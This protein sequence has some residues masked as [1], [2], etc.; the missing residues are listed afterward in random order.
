MS[1]KQT[2][3]EIKQILFEETCT[4]EQLNVFKDDPRKG[5]QQLIQ[6]YE[7]QLERKAMLKEKF[8][9]MKVF[10]DT[11][12]QKG[13]Q[14]IAGIDEAGRGPLAGPVVAAA[15]MLDD[16]FYLEG[17]NDSKELNEEQRET[18]F[19]Y[20]KNHA[21]SYGIGIVD[22]EEIDQINIYEATKTAMKRA[23][24]LL[25]PAPDQL[26][27]DAVQL[28]ESPIPYEAIVKGDQ[29]SISIAAASVLAKVTR[30]RY[31]KQIH[32]EYPFYEFGSNMGYGTRSHLDALDKYGTT[33]YHRHSFAPVKKVFQTS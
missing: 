10:E 3:R 30:D 23:I 6:R 7:K 18:Y 9:Q 26:L 1:D 31:M 17:L 32:K 21:I 25:Y 16:G 20:I 2:I 8:L 15:V 27:I 12:R 22:N 4:R 33:P 28:H 11:Y 13:K 24:D 5:V 29:R 19:D 14:Y